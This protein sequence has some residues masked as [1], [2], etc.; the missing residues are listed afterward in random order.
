[1]HFIKHIT[2]PM[3]LIT[4]QNRTKHQIGGE[5]DED[6][7]KFFEEYLK[8]RTVEG[9]RSA[10][11]ADRSDKHIEQRTFTLARPAPMEVSVI[12]VFVF[13]SNPRA[14]CVERWFFNYAPFVCVEL[15]HMI[16]HA[17]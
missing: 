9:Y 10:Y 16:S 17:I 5:L 3:H 11:L 14:C 7:A 12:C 4:Y 13:V 2:T 1:M 8:V 6:E 15:F